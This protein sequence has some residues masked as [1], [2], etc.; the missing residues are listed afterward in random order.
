LLPNGE[1]LPNDERAKRIIASQG[2]VPVEDQ[3]GGLHVGVK[4][5]E[6]VVAVMG[7][8]GPLLFQM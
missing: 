6:G 5:R 7:K 3:D 2:F 4:V 8:E 1:R